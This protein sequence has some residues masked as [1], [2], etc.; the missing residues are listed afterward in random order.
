MEGMSIALGRCMEVGVS[1]DYICGKMA[2]S[3]ELAVRSCGH[4]E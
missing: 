4:E 2:D 1:Q 3:V